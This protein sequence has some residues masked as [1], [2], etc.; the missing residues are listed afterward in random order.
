MRSKSEVRD[1][2][3]G[4]SNELTANLVYEGKEGCQAGGVYRCLRTDGHADAILQPVT[5]TETLILMTAPM[6]L[7][8]VMW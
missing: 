8:I 7:S 3:N 2:Q 1:I 5:Y 6:M 4:Q